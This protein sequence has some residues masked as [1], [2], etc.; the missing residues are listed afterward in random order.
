MRDPRLYDAALATRARTWDVELYA[1]LAGRARPPVLEIGGGTGRILLE[2]LR[3]GIDAYAVEIDPAM[4]AAGQ[5][6]LRALGPD[7]A[8]RLEVADARVA[9][10]ARGYGLVIAPYNVLSALLTE[11]D[12]RAALAQ[13]ARVAAP[14]AQLVFDV[15]VAEALA[16]S[17]P[18]YTWS[19][20]PCALPGLEGG[21]LEEGGT[22]DPEARLHRIKQTFHLG[23]TEVHEQLALRPWREAELIEALAATGWAWQSPAWNQRRVPRVPGDSI[24]IGRALRTA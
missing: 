4:A 18:P 20:P 15:I 12:L 21:T 16:W 9:L 17:R 2:L 10:P 23:G 14:G 19:A 7:A 24:L 6:K 22:F 1:G 3:A 11:G 5:E 8:E 13:M